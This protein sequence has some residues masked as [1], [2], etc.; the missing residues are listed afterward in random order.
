MELIL[1]VDWVAITIGA[2]LG[3]IL[4]MAWYSKA[5]FVEKW[6]AGKGTSV[7]AWPMII[8]MF[9]QA[10]GTFL[11][12]WA[13]GVSI[14]L[15][16][17]AFAVLIACSAGAL[18]KANGLFAGKSAYAIAV[19]SVFVLVMCAVMIATHFVF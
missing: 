15:E 7:Y 19:E 1:T 8:P 3:Y 11:I 18:I 17:V 14:A 13:I 2:V 4:G 9:T 5:L 12:S 6:V 10:V 16:S